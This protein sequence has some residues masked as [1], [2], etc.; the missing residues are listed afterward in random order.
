M[1]SEGTILIYKMWVAPEGVHLVKQYGIDDGHIAE[2]VAKPG[3]HWARLLDLQEV[4]EHGWKALVCIYCV[5]SRDV[6]TEFLESDDFKFK[7]PAERKDF[8]KYIRAEFQVG[9]IIYQVGKV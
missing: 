1:N 6:L 3:F 2:V 5:D 9:D 7:Y 8:E 4:D